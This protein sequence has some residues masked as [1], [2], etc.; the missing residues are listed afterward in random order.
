MTIS[1]ADLLYTE[2]LN[3]QLSGA[4]Q[5]ARLS[6][7]KVLQKYPNHADAMHQLGII[8]LQLGQIEEAVSWIQKSVDTDPEQ[9]SAL[10]N[11]GYCLNKI[12]KYCE[13][14]DICK[15]AL[16]LNPTLDGGWTN[17]G[18]AQRHL[19]LIDDARI[20]YTRAMSLQPSSPR[21]IYNLGVTYLFQDV[22]D[23]AAALFEKCLSIDDR[24]PEAH[25]NLSACY[26]KLN[27]YERALV[28]IDLAIELNANYLEA[29]VNRGF[30]LHKLK[31]H[32]EAL[33]SYKRAIELNPNYAEA[34]NNRGNSLNQLRRH[35]EALES[36]KRAIELNPN[37][38]EAWSNL[39]NSL[40]QLRRY[41]EALES[42]QRAIDLK[43]DF[44]EAWRLYANLLNDLNHHEQALEAYE[45]ALKLNPGLDFALG[46]MIFTQL[47]ACNWINLNSRLEFLK[48]RILKGE[49]VSSPFVAIS[50]YDSPRLANVATK[51]YISEIHNVTYE[52]NQIGK[53]Q[54]REKIRIGYFSMDFRNHPVSYLI[55]NLI[56]LHDR[57]KFE[58]FGVSFGPNTKD[59][60]RQRLENSF[61][62][63]EDVENLDDLSIT[64]KSRELGIDIA[65][66]LGGHTKFSRPEIFSGRAAPLQINYLGYPGTTGMQE[67]DYMIA[68]SS[69]ISPSARSQYAEKIIYLPNSYQANDS[70]MGVTNRI[71]TR[72]ELGLPES[73]FIFC[74]F[75]SSQKIMPEIFSCWMQVLQSVDNSVL[76]LLDTNSSAV[77]NL[78]REANAEGINPERIV[79]AKAMTHED[80]LARY[81]LA[82]LFLDT[83][84][85][86]A[87]TTASDA[88]RAGVP[89]LTLLGN[90]F[91]GRVASSL[92]KS[93][94]LEELVSHSIEEYKC[95]AITLA[96]SP[97]QLISM[98]HKL[99]KNRTSTPLFDT[100]LI[101]QHIEMAYQIAY[102]R[103]QSGLAPADIWI[104]S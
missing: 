89:V 74:C 84:P 38:A 12:G 75:N 20:S 77:F 46:E 90:A 67:L 56:E 78:R 37:Y 91:A 92:L 19:G 9:P 1:N 72:D 31:R 104:R 5:E 52:L 97:Q 32:H 45:K 7:Q 14:V 28:H 10:S 29:H 13:S 87:H 48:E 25:N 70:N 21:Y 4:T 51:A 61:D 47:K 59:S 63:F 83:L 11:L 43:P 53:R 6:Y 62:H 16:Q 98:K 17:L 69:V 88:L 71:F 50:L 85:Y 54:R 42:Y 44:S 18:N 58:V 36:Y 49:R 34:W 40:N 94:G 79:F 3:K 30:T 102:D 76:W 95:R 68:D 2:A 35:Q 39:G 99:L 22:F 96:T 80:H 24:I 73:G 64:R 27:K 100:P 81:R 26:L 41:Q 57:T 103:Y 15:K 65:I 86:N 66:D 82:D 60:M 101:T 23:E 55:A 93:I 8:H 33:E